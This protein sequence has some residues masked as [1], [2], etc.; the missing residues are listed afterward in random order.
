MTDVLRPFD[1]PDIG[2]ADATGTQ[3]AR[4]PPG[5]T[6]DGRQSFGPLPAAEIENGAPGVP[7]AR[8]GRGRPHGTT[9]PDGHVVEEVR[10]L[11]QPIP[12]V[13]TLREAARQVAPRAHNYGHADPLSTVKRI[14]KAYRAAHST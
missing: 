1:V 14:E 4:R 6:V 2:S 3:I 5:E 9:Y 12:L 7:Q 8:R 13:P 10:R 11:L